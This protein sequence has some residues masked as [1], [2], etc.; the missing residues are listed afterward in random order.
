MTAGGVDPK[1]ID[2]G[3]PDANGKTTMDG[4]SFL[5]VLQGKSITHREVV[6]AQHTTHGIINGSK[7]YASRAVCDGRWK[8]INN[9]HSNRRSATPSAEVRC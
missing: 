7:A 5:T 1:T 9:L 8:L 4:I 3:C 6:F 2:T